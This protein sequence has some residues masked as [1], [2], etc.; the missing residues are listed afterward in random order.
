VNGFHNV[1]TYKHSD[2]RTLLFTADITGRSSIYDL[3]RLLAGDPQQGRVGAV[4]GGPGTPDLGAFGRAYH[5]F[6]VA[7]DPATHQDKFYGAASRNYFV[8]DVTHPE[9]PKLLA[10]ITGVPGLY[11]GHTIQ[12]TPDGRYAITYPEEEFYTE[13]GRRNPA[14]V[15]DLKPALDGQTPTLSRSI[16]A[17]T[18][19]WQNFVHN[20]EMRWPYVF[21]SSYEDGLQVINLMDPTNPYTTGY[22]YTCNCPHEQGYGTSVETGRKT[23]LNGAWGIDVRNADG[24]IVISD[25]ATGFWSFKMDGFDGW[26][27]HQWG[28]PNISSVQD[29]DR[30]PEGASKPQKVS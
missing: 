26:N 22:Y 27:G 14:R 6:Y 25:L 11:L 5:D 30:G 7:Y 18:P 2:G 15:F 17:W 19:D 4:P 21:A 9:A 12:A 13:S 16:G 23:V 28:M 8:Y 24:L 1:Y 20:F 3:E 10:T 29:W